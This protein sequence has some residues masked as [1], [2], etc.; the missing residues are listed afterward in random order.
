MQIADREEFERHL[1]RLCAGFDTPLTPQRKDAYW[2]AFSR[3]PLKRFAWLVEAALADSAFETMPTVGALRK[4]GGD[5]NGEAAQKFS[6]PQGPTLQEQISEFVMATRYPSAEDAKFTYDQMRQ[7][8]QPWTFLY[9][10]WRDEKG[11]RAAECIG[12]L[13]PACGALAGF[14][15]SVGDMRADPRHTAVLKKLSGAACDEA[16]A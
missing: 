11:N 9:R 3:L 6:G 12:V 13:V 10:E 16:A 14:F 4:L 7:A 2:A 5:G 15:V 8:S 1:G